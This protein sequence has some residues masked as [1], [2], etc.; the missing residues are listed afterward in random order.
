MAIN[1]I[2]PGCHARFKV[3]DQFAGKKGPC[4]K[5]KGTIQVPKLDEQVIV[6]E[7]EHSEVGARSATGQLVLKPIERKETVIQPMLIAGYVAGAFV[8]LLVALVLRNVGDKTP[9]LVLGAIALA[10]PLVWG[11]YSMLRDDEQLE[12][13]A[14]LELWIRVGICSACYAGLWWFFGFIYGKFFGDAPVDLVS[15]G[16]MAPVFLFLG[17]GIAAG[18]FDFD[19]GVGF[20]HYSLYL[21]VTVV[22]RMVM[23]LPPVGPAP[24]PTTLPELPELTSLLLA[25]SECWRLL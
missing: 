23:G 8:A 22:M 4:P 25:A 13:F 2:C 12:S 24:Q 6:H 18:C 7:P 20:F 11:G 3:S 1:V 10:P 21:V 16:I 19:L 15:G 17:A 14:G 5:C 9:L